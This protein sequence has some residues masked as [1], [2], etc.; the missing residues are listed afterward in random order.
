MTWQPLR[1]QLPS[2]D[3]LL[4]TAILKR[5]H[6]GKTKVGLHLHVLASVA[7]MTNNHKVVATVAVALA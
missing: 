3:C 2:F 4:A 7:T 1:A 5:N 6:S